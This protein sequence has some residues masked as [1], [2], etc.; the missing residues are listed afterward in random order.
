MS[1]KSTTR[2]PTLQEVIR[3]AFDYYLEDLH[4]ALPGKVESYDA[5]EQR[6]TVQPLVNRRVVVEEGE[7]L[8]EQLP[9]IPDVPI[10]FPRSGDFFLTFPIKRGDLVTLVFQERSIE[11]PRW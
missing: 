5:E 3:Q 7:T 9:S 6:A 2:T 10:A 4:V 8:T 1:T 11:M